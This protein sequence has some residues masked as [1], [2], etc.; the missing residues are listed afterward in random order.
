[1][2]DR[3][4][5]LFDEFLDRALRRGSADLDEYLA[6]H[7]ELDAEERKRLRQL[8]SA[9]EVQVGAEGPPSPP[10]FETTPDLPKPFGPYVLLRLLGRGGQGVVY[11]ARDTRLSRRVAL[12]VLD[13]VGSLT[14]ADESSHGAAAR[15]KREAEVASKLEHP[16]I[17]V[18]HEMGVVGHSLYVAMRYVEG[19]TLARTIAASRESGRKVLRLEAPSAA[20]FE[21]GLIERGTP[22]TAGAGLAE[23]SVGYRR[24]MLERCARLVESAAR[25][26]HA[27]HE[28]GVIHRDIKPANIM[29]TPDVQPVIL[30]F[31]LARDQSSDALTLTRTGEIF[32]SPGYMSPEQVSRKPSGLDRRTDIYSLGVVLYECL[33]LQRPFEHPTRD[34][35]FRAI[36]S[37]NPPDPRRLNAGID[38]ELSIVLETALEKDRDRRYRT[39]LDFAE[40]LRRWREY[41]PILARPASALL[42][43]KRWTQRN[44]VL[45]ASLLGIFALLVGLLVAAK[46][47]IQRERAHANEL[48]GALFVAG[49]SAVLQTDPALALRLAIEGVHRKEGLAANNALRAAL[50]RIREFR[51]IGSR[52]SGSI[53]VATTPDGQ[54]VIAGWKDGVVRMWRTSDWNP[55]PDIRLP[56]GQLDELHLTADGVRLVT[57]SIPDS[58]IRAW[59]ASDWAASSTGD[60]PLPEL[61]LRLPEPL[62]A[63]PTWSPDGL[64][65]LVLDPQRVRLFDIRTGAVPASEIALVSIQSGIWDRKGSRALIV[66]PDRIWNPATGET[67][68]L[69]GTVDA[70]AGTHCGD[71]SPEGRLVADASA[72]GGACVWRTE[73][74]SLVARVAEDREARTT[75]FGPDGGTLF[76]GCA[77]GEGLLFETGSWKL[78]EKYQGHSESVSDATFSLDG[79]RITTIAQDGTARVWDTSS[80]K[81][82]AALLSSNPIT[83]V[84][85]IGD[86]SRLATGDVDGNVRLWHRADGWTRGI[87]ESAIPADTYVG[88]CFD[89]SGGRV[90]LNF[91]KDVRIY[92]AHTHARVGVLERRTGRVHQVVFTSDG[93]SLLT[94]SEDATVEIWDAATFRKTGE[95][96]HEEH[97]KPVWSVDV[98]RDGRYAVTAS[99]EHRV[100]L[101]DLGTHRLVRELL[102]E[103]GKGVQSAYFSP[104]GLGIV[105]TCQGDRTIRVWNVP[106]GEPRF[107]PIQS[108]SWDTRPRICRFS[109]DSRFLVACSWDGTLAVWNAANRGLLWQKQSHGALVNDASFSPDGRRIVSGSVDKTVRIWDAA[110]GDQ[111]AILSGHKG[112]V[113]FVLYSPDGRQI[114]SIASDLVARLTPTDPIAA[115]MEYD[116]RELTGEEMAR[117]GLQVV[118][119]R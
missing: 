8:S 28:S 58:T 31:G 70:R 43:V 3:I 64:R 44:R 73:D 38:R 91:G 67:V 40:D 41:E 93:R 84:V 23:D 87:L 24:R 79:S 86:G 114:L 19:Q 110:N 52:K 66:G 95:V 29:V 69:E 92:D 85:E 88:G 65:L 7:P 115:A 103:D 49:S 96:G 35:L 119:S 109:P 50:S 30:D 33:T 42:R 118:E 25:A 90:A 32:G 5:D 15:L 47:V 72:T 22:S 10:S 13:H 94:A 81:E 51:R 6:A 16:G 39:A 11:L 48:S 116:P 101:F 46:F 71:F 117:F 37:E 53:R 18:V 111:L 34:E 104:D 1:M 97:Q 83:S 59:S 57:T 54:F 21:N 9:L 99:E 60:P 56:S 108:T 106:G 45:T 78:L 2:A 4:E 112:H 61:E 27:A 17:C 98:S 63:T 12:K 20:A 76:V 26:L 107:P 105:S 36:Q 62:T 82:E 102:H 100:R 74:G 14:F 55:A 89:P 75:R 113:A 68:R 77:D 80:D